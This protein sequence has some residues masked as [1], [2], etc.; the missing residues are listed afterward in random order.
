MSPVLSCIGTATTDAR[1]PVF[2]LSEFVPLQPAV[3]SVDHSFINIF[4]LGYFTLM[5]LFFFV[6]V[7]RCTAHVLFFVC[8]SQPRDYSHAGL[9]NCVYAQSWWFRASS[10]CVEKVLDGL[11]VSICARALVLPAAFGYHAR[12]QQPCPRVCDSFFP[13]RCNFPTVDLPF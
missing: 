12:Q 11:R 13:H 7:V 4:P 2:V 5:A 3:N 9:L 1:L 6:S 8:F 10:K